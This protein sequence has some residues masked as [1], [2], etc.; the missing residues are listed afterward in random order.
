M[1]Q[2]S[3]LGT[4]CDSRTLPN[5][6]TKSLDQLLHLILLPP[7]TF[8]REI[9]ARL[10]LIHRWPLSISIN[11]HRIVRSISHRTTP[12]LSPQPD[13]LF[14]T[15]TC[16]TLLRAR[17]CLNPEAWINKLRKAILSQLRMAGFSI[18]WQKLLKTLDPSPKRRRLLRY[19]MERWTGTVYSAPRT[20]RLWRI[21]GLRSGKTSSVYGTC[22]K[23]RLHP[24]QANKSLCTFPFPCRNT[25][26]RS[27][28]IPTKMPRKD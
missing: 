2:T 12:N 6:E 9:P 4:S 5:M 1:I 18:C 23:L 28:S 22:Q 26:A 16:R 27:S 19:L 10:C 24:Q 20:L 15:V 17:V 3:A 25:A 11:G 8:S 13:L 7:N 21:H 14:Q